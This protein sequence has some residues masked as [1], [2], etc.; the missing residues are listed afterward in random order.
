MYVWMYVPLS[1]ELRSVDSIDVTSVVIN[2]SLQNF[3]QI[4][5]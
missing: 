4:L 1:K 5:K 2:V 3:D